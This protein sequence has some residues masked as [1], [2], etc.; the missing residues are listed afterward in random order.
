MTQRESTKFEAR[1]SKQIQNDEKQ[2][3][4]N[5]PNGTDRIHCFGFSDFEFIL[6]PVCFGF[7]GSD[8]GFTHVGF[9]SVRGA[10]FDIRISDLF[11]WMLGAITYFVTSECN[12]SGGSD[13]WQ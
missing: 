12:I 3:N 2:N 1:S 5:A 13:E 11:R 8:F 10:S 6:V 7:L 4:Y 9:V